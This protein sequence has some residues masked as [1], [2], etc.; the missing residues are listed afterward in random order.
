MAA[1]SPMNRAA[2]ADEMIGPVMFLVSDAGSFMT[3]QVVLA[4]GG[5]GAALTV[6]R[7][8]Q[9]RRA[10]RRSRTIIEVDEES[11]GAEPAAPR[12]CG[13]DATRAPRRAADAVAGIIGT[14]LFLLV[15]GGILGVA[16]LAVAGDDSSDGSDR[17]HVRRPVR[18]RRRCRTVVGPYKVTTGVNVRTGP[19]LNFP[20]VGTVETGKPVFVVCVVEGGAVDG[21]SGP[22]TKW[23]QPHRVRPHRLR[24]RPVRRHRR[25]PQRLGP[26]PALRHLTPTRRSSGREVGQ[27]HRRRVRGVV[28]HGLVGG[29]HVDRGLGGL[30][31]AEVARVHRVRS[32]RHLHPERG[33]RRR[34]GGRSA[35]PPRVRGTRRRRPGRSTAG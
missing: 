7:P 27:H 31:G 12:A 2:H 24:D 6:A 21:P 33:A 22:V 35:T 32:A 23:L 5:H 29:D 16:Y 4:D 1:A 18:R 34:S 9:P 8:G 11:G 25:R 30:A 26:D 13:T 15:A 3:G 17:V 20:T 28:Q 14:L 19:G 10:T